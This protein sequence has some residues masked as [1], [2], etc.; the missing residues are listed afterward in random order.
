MIAGITE[1][2]QK[3]IER[4][5]DK[6]RKDYAFFYYGSRVK[7][8]YEK[9]SDLDVLI[10]GKAEMPL[11]VLQEIKE[12]FDKS[13]LPYIVNFSDYYKLDSS[14][15]ERIKPDLI[16]YNWQEVK[17]GDVLSFRY[18]KM[19]NKNKILSKGKYPI[20]TGYRYAGFYDEYN[21]EKNQL[22]IVARGVGGTGD[23]KLSKEQCFLTNLS[24]ASSLK[25]RQVDVKYLFYYFTLHSLRYLDSGSAQSQI[26]INDL[27]KIII[28][29]P[30]L[31]VQKKIAG[32]LGALD[33]K[34]VL[35]NK[36]NQNLE[37]Q[38]QALF[39]SWFID[40]E[41]FGGKMPDDWKIG[42]LG[43]IADITMGQSP[44]G[45]SYNE[46]KQGCIFFQG[47]AEFG[48]RFPSVRLYTTEPKRMAKK[49]DILMSV[50]ASVG[51]FNIAVEDCCIGRGLCSIRA[52][53]NFQSFVLYTIW[54]LQKQLEIFNG[55]GTVFGAINKDSLNSLPI[56]IPSLANIGQFENI[57]SSLDNIIRN[58]FL[59]NTRLAELRDTLLPKLMSGEINVDDVKI[60]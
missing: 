12:E 5:L 51:D 20:F 44:N 25:T 3:I 24:I 46:D 42:K 36:I 9:T 57:V 32:V 28:L 18:G 7:G 45:S 54:S 49:N 58:N 27:E 50:R 47:R 8:T 11:A 33:D 31:D 48:K 41:P 60:D 22:I 29:L 30:S 59:E 43:E 15:Y 34:I 26:T 38:A 21:I 17:L 16:P 55:E 53:G 56:T 23:V 19:P 1:K 14:F 39:K 2:E 10:K 13:D 52:K 4:I 40:F 6:Y 37:A 35:N